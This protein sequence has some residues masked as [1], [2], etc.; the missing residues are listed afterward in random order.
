MTPAGILTAFVAIFVSMIMDHGQP[1]S[2]IKIPALLLVFG[3][4]IGAT[5][6]GGVKKDASLLPK[7][8]MVAMKPGKGYNPAEFT[9][10]LIELAR[11]ART[12]G[13][14][15]LE[16]ELPEAKD[17]PFTRTGVELITTTSDPERVRMVLDAEIHGIRQRHRVGYKA[18]QD[19]AGYAPTIGILGTVIGLVHVLGSLTSPG[20][21]GPAIASA[22]TATL[23]GVLTANVVWLPIGNKL[24]RLS[25]QEIAYKELVVEGLLAVQEGISGPQLKDRLVPFLPPRERPADERAANE[26]AA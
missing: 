22:F 18:F 26:S 6:A 17:D 13:L 21:L 5:I 2:L 3:G 10:H 23:W 9:E 24:K 25:D 11:A 4:T 15:V 8:F 7:A 16:R 14:K 1:G 12:G 19:M 20:T